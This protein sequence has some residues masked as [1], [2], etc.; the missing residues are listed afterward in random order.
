MK[1]QES[2]QLDTTRQMVK[3]RVCS[4]YR[5]TFALEVSWR[6][7][8]RPTQFVQL[9]CTVFKTGQD[10]MNTHVRLAPTIQQPPF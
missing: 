6:L 4:A 8:N 10:S 1:F 2:A 7:V 3:P 9:A 5:A